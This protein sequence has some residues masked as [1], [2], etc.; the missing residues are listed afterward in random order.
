MATTHME[1]GEMAKYGIAA[2]L[3]LLV[4]ARLLMRG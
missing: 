2:A 4:L 3:V 1:W